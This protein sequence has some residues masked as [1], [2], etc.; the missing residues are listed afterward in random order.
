[1]EIGLIYGVSPNPITV[2]LKKNNIEL[3]RPKYGYKKLVVCKDGHKVKSNLERNVCDWLHEKGIEHEYEPKYHKSKYYGNS[4]KADFK[5]GKF[6]IEILGML[7]I[8]KY[9]MNFEKKTTQFMMVGGAGSACFK[10]EDYELYK[11]LIDKENK[12]VIVIVEPKKKILSKEEITRQIGF[13]IPLFSKN[14]K[15]LTT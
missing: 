6:N 3:N 15:N 7:G 2:L 5:I 9:E 12:D 1:I 10:G 4:F 14:Q 11:N 8:P 13:L